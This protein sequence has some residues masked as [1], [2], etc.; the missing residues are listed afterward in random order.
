[1]SSKI[2]NP[3]GFDSEDHDLELF[4]VQLNVDLLEVARLAGVDTPRVWMDPSLFSGI[5]EG[6]FGGA[7]GGYTPPHPTSLAVNIHPQLT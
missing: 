3:Y 2:V 7:A 6:V 5:E 4:G 1:M